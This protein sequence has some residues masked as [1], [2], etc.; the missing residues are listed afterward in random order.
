MGV[1]SSSSPRGCEHTLRRGGA[2]KQNTQ[3]SSANM[4]ATFTGYALR[5]IIEPKWPP[6]LLSCSVRMGGTSGRLGS[7]DPRRARLS[8]SNMV[9][10]LADLRFL[11]MILLL[12][13]IRYGA[14]SQEAPQVVGLRLEDPEGLVRMKDR[15]ISA[16][17]GATFKLR[18]FGANL[19]GSWPTVAFAGADE[20]AAGAIGDAP[21]PCEKENSRRDSA[22]QVT[23]KVDPDEEYSGLLTVEVK[24]GS[25]SAGF[26]HLC[27]QSGERWA[28]VGPDRLR[29]STAS[30][31]PA[32][33]IP[34]WGLALLVV[35]MLL[36]CGLLRTVNLS[37]LWL[38]PVELYVLHSCG[39]EEEKRAAKRLEPIRRRGNF[40]TC[41]LLFLCALGHSVLGVLLYRALGSIVSAVFTSGFLIFFLAELAPHILCSGYGFQLA[42][43]LAWLGQ[44]CMMLTC[45]LSCPLGLILDLG[46]RRDISTCGIRE[47]A[48]EMIRASVN[49][50][51]SEFVKEEF[52]RGMLRTKTVED[53]LTPLK[54]CFMLPSSAVLD[55][56]TMSEIMQSGYTRVPIYEEER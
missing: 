15:I 36:I 4:Y 49:D 22:F 2:L 5:S 54:D 46:L 56:S 19:N 38:D 3:D 55:F 37:L 27:V 43:G 32:D 11:L 40:L 12:C 50:P 35:L 7:H 51:Y 44:V 18:L 30:G 1:S 10:S 21:D 34:P 29:I 9:A 26:H 41:S 48:M 31:L 33:H 47:R 39:S 20:G 14:C 13:G 6:K 42:P 8:N 17:E 23:E 52:S 25:I 45:P 53:I 24:H 28:S 16:P